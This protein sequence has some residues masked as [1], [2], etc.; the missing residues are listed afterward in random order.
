MIKIKSV[1]KLLKFKEKVV[2][3]VYLIMKLIKGEI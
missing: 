1:V 2:M 3:S